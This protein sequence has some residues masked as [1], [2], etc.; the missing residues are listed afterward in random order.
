M[1]GHFFIGGMGIGSATPA[2]GGFVTLSGDAAGPSNA[3]VVNS[4]T[5]TGGAVTVPATTSLRFGALPATAGTIRLT[6]NE[7][8]T[9]RNFDNTANVI[10]AQALSTGELQ[11]GDVTVSQTY[12]QSS[13]FVSI[14]PGAVATTQFA[15]D[16][17]TSLVALEVYTP[18]GGTIAGSGDI[19]FTVGGS[20]RARNLADDQDITLLELTDGGDGIADSILIGS[21][22]VNSIVPLGP[23]LGSGTSLGSPY[24]CHGSVTLTVASSMAYTMSSVESRATWV[25]LA[26]D[27]GGGGADVIF[28]C[29][30]GD[31]ATKYIMNTNSVASD[32]YFSSGTAASAR[33]NSVTVVRSNGTNLVRVASWSAI[34]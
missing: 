10:I 20:I 8:I 21:K 2:S 24:S 25:I 28:D 15:N 22:E 30:H 6:N 31:G 33:A 13:T 26:E 23:I 34:P 17:T 1:A 32:I 7:T 27:G 12:L 9:S 18:G 3:N 16:R 11:F 19:R 14:Y 4:L 5:G 29:L